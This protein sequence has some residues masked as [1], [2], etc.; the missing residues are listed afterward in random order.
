MGYTRYKR[1]MPINEYIINEFKVGIIGIPHKIKNIDRLIKA[2]DLIKNNFNINIKLCL[3]IPLFEDDNMKIE[4]LDLLY[5]INNKDI[6]II[7]YGMYNYEEMSNWF[8]QINCY[9]NVSSAEGWSYTP[10]EALYLG[11]PT[12]I[13]NIPLHDELCASDYFNIIHILNNNKIKVSLDND[14]YDTYAY[15]YE[16]YIKDIINSI[17]YVYN[18]YNLC[19]IKSSK[20]SQWIK[21]KWNNEDITRKIYLKTLGDILSPSPPSGLTK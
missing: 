13:T 3:H 10:R 5:T 7:T 16:I 2:C 12:I 14:I 6:F 20:G 18:N 4:F 8:S 17:M 1:I 9:I 19:L 15:L 11:I 21:D